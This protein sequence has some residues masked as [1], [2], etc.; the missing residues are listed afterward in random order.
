MK[1]KEIIQLILFILIVVMAV[2]SI[3]LYLQSKDDK[4]NKIMFEG[5]VGH[6]LFQIY[7]NYDSIMNSE[8]NTIDEL[9]EVHETLSV[10]QGNSETID[11]VYNTP[12]LLPISKS[13]A[14]V[15]DQVIS[16]Y[17]E[18]QNFSE[19][20][21]KNIA[22]VIDEAKKIIPLIGQ[23]YYVSGQN[24]ESPKVK[25]KISNFEDL[26]DLHRR[27]TNTNF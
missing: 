20:D 9:M 6:T 21:L 22:M 16:N 25:K 13:L 2:S 14:Q 26:T 3:P 19:E 18:N 24:S 4:E 12:L 8:P 1:I 5:V 11:F 10:I 15:T 23:V 27:I 17:R 7:S